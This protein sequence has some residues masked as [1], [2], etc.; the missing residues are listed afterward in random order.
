[1]RLNV[2]QVCNSSMVQLRPFGQSSGPT[3]CLFGAPTNWS[4]NKKGLHVDQIRTIVEIAKNTGAKRLYLPDTTDENSIVAT[5]EEFVWL[6]SDK[7]HHLPIYY[8]PNINGLLLQPNAAYFAPFGDEP[9]IVAR[10]KRNWDLVVAKASL[11]NLVRFPPND[12]RL[13]CRQDHESVIEEK[14]KL[15]SNQCAN[16]HRRYPL[17]VKVF[18]GLPTKHFYLP[19]FNVRP[20][21][22]KSHYPPHM[23]EH[24]LQ[25]LE[26]VISRWG[27]C[28]IDDPVYGQLCLETII[29]K[30]FTYY[31]KNR[32]EITLKFSPINIY[33]DAYFDRS[34][35]CSPANKLLWH[36]EARSGKPSR[37]GVLV[38][39][40]S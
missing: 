26:K 3:V 27:N 36:C 16:Q 30:Q 17:E 37:N 2:T 40:S 19:T 31:G 12:P 34:V 5:P 13:V 28:L 39:N 18:G 10:N 25:L 29:S 1:M 20:L 35:D 21:D 9:I 11:F 4:P 7:N 22:D 14:I 24:N 33:E 15:L 6:S 38:V 23:G 32:W 8:G